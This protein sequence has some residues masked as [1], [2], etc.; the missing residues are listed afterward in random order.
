MKATEL[1]E[2][3]EIF[4]KTAAY[5]E[6]LEAKI[7]NSETQLVQLSKQA[8]EAPQRN[9]ITS[10]A[11]AKLASAGFTQADIEALSYLP[12]DAIEKVAGLASQPWGMGGGTGPSFEG[13]LDPLSSF[14]LGMK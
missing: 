12:V 4:V 10:D 2:I 1:K 7:E 9:E 8:S 5:I 14:L 11:L 13:N 6:E 3:S